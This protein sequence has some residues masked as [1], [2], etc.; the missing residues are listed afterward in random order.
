MRLVTEVTVVCEGRPLVSVEKTDHGVRAV[1]ADA[2]G[3]Q[4][5]TL[6]GKSRGAI[7]EVLED[8][9]GQVRNARTWPTP[10]EVTGLCLQ[11]HGDPVDGTRPLCEYDAG[12][13]PPC[14]L[15]GLSRLE[16]HADEHKDEYEAAYRLAELERAAHGEPA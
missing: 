4:E 3:G 12:H 8:V 15:K 2:A 16:E 5:F 9:A 1:V 11:P 7:A 14:G 13:I 6:V 10:R